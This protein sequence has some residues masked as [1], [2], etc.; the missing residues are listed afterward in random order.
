M[1]RLDPWRVAHAPRCAE[2]GIDPNFL[3]WAIRGSRVH[4]GCP[5]LLFLA[6]GIW[7][8]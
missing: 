3:M 6:A 1:I 2:G 5:L 7:R 8:R 4:P